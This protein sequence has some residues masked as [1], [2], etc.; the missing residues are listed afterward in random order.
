[1]GT[2]ACPRRPARGLAVLALVALLTSCS[3]DGS[4]S[5]RLPQGGAAAGAE[6][7]EVAATRELHVEPR[8]DD[9]GDGSAAKPFG[10]LALALPQL[11][12]GDTLLVGAGT[13]R[14]RIDTKVRSGRPDAPIRVRPA[15][16]GRVLLKG[17]LWLEEPDWWSVQGLS[18][19]WDD[20]NRSDEHLVKITGGDDWIMSDAEIWGARSFAA[21]LVVGDPE[22]FTLRRLHVHD[23]APTN[24]K[25]QDH[26]IYLNSGKGGGVVEGCLLVGSPNG[27]AVKI[28]PADDGG[29]RVSK[30]VVRYNTMVDNLGPSNVQL[31]W[32]S[33]KNEIY[34]NVMV[35]SGPGRANVT[36]FKLDGGKNSVRDNIGSQSTGV[37]EQGVGGLRDDGGNRTLDPR[38][39]DVGGLRYVPTAP[40]TAGFGHTALPPS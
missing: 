28:G 30:V 40:G 11:R 6:R 10:S 34:R 17:L 35:R 27:R 31:A 39:R 20:A 25:N 3:A 16:T 29:R 1:M 18:V 36:A 21:V 15:G 14:E 22:R 37:L 24:G 2:A 23:T 13:Y 5:S 12:A 32:N 8:N 38:L 26:L 9:T 7:P 19:T 4:Q 33:T